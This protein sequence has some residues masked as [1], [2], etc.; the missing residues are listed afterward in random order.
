MRVFVVDEEPMF[1]GELHQLPAAVSSAPAASVRPP[2]R[3]VLVVDDH[4]DTADALARVL[5]A[6]GHLALPVHSG[7]SAL[8]AVETFQ[9]DVVLL[10]LGMPVMD[11]LEV[12]RRLRARPELRDLILVAATGHGEL[13]DRQRSLLAGFDHHLVKPLTPARIEAVLGAPARTPGAGPRRPRAS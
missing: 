12:A 8:A 4:R 7:Q 13:D 5:E 6:Y 9:P 3:R 10:D 1:G 2:P 11:G